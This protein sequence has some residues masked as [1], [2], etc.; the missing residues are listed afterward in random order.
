MDPEHIQQ[1]LD[2]ILGQIGTVTQRIRE[3]QI[4]LTDFRRQ[5]G[6]RLDNIERF[7]NPVANPNTRPPSPFVEEIHPDVDHGFYFDEQGKVDILNSPFFDVSSGHD[8]TAEDYVERILYQLTL[9]IEDQIPTGRWCL[10]SRRPSSPNLATSPATSI[11]GFLLILVASLVV[12]RFFAVKPSLTKSNDLEDKRPAK[13]FTL[14]EDPRQV[15]TER[16]QAKHLPLQIDLKA[17]VLYEHK[18]REL[19]HEEF[20]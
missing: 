20:N 8:P 6:E 5:T 4:E 16:Y 1:T 18:Q 15:A 9:A 11:R 3:T 17:D 7:G 14:V 12:T 10:V 2:L 13:R 19:N